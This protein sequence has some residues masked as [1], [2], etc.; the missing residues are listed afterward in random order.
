MK[1]IKGIVIAFSIILL[2]WI[3]SLISV[4]GKLY[5]LPCSQF[6]NISELEKWE[7][8]YRKDVTSLSKELEWWG[9]MEYDTSSC[10]WKVGIVFY[11]NGKFDKKIIQ[12][13]VDNIFYFRGIPYKL[14]NF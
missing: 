7:K 2:Y 3:F 6:L 4:Y 10:P 11:Y 13:T 5:F 12:S 1:I 14:V 8:E 9:Y